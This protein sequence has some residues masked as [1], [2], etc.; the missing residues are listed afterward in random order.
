MNSEPFSNPVT[1]S[2]V[3]F[4]AD[5]GIET[6][7]GELHEP[8]FLPGI[9]IDGGA[10]V[11]DEA[12]LTY[13]GDLLHEAGHLAVVPPERRSAMAMYAGDDPAEEMMAIAWSYAAAL[14]I[15]LGID[16][17]FHEGGYK[18]WSSA[19]IENFS[20]GQYFGVP[21]LQW[22]GLT[23][24]EKRAGELGV[25]PYPHMIRWLREKGE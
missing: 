17:V 18:G 10:L 22:I 25:K 7:R 11:I 2:I 23:C 20:N 15:G 6:R 19:I 21:V 4:L 14:H 5:I 8:T 3:R 1:A 12:K 24:E 16:V 9:G 13:P